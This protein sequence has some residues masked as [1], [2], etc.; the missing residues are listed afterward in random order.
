MRNKRY[1]RRKDRPFAP[2]IFFMIEL[3]VMVE[4][5]YMYN[6]ILGEGSL[7]LLFHSLIFLYLI[8]NSV[9]RLFRVL[10]R[11]KLHKINIRNIGSNRY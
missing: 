1:E 11:T 5:S 10:E 4:L 3:V 6:Y 7:A 9:K 8:V 2:Y